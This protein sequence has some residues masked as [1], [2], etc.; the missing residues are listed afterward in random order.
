MTP[1]TIQNN[2]G[3]TIMLKKNQKSWLLIGISIASFIGCIDFT[4]VNTALPAIQS[5]FNVKIADLQWVINIFILA[6]SAFMVIAG[7]VADVYGR[8]KILYIGM[9]VFGISSLFVG[10]ATNIY[11]LILGR[12]L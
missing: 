1:T 6:L 2:S 5:A 10:L 12:F 8:R 3:S 11:Y 7:K 4:I 9:I